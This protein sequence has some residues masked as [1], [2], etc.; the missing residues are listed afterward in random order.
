MAEAIDSPLS[1]FLS[2]RDGCNSTKSEFSDTA[3]REGKRE[4][5]EF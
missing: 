2:S 1:F 3:I 5:L 4:Y